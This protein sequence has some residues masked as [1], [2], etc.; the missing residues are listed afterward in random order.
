MCSNI[1]SRTWVKRLWQLLL[2][3]RQGSSWEFRVWFFGDAE[4]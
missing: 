2:V 1:S 3:I 4:D